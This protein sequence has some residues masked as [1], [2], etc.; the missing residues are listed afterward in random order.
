MTQQPSLPF[1]IKFCG[2]R[3]ARDVV[4]AVNLGAG[5]FGYNFYPK[6]SRFV[7]ASQ[8]ASLIKASKADGTDRGLSI[9]VFVNPTIEEL[10]DIL[11]IC[12]LDAIQLHGDETPDFVVN[13]TLPPIIKAISWRENSSEDE[14][15]ASAWKE[16]A[17]RF[18][19]L[20]FLVDAYDPIQRGGTGKQA[21]WDLLYPRPEP[22]RDVPLILAGGL[23]AENVQQAVLATRADAVDTASGIETQP[24]LKNLDKMRSFIEEAR[25]GFT[26]I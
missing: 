11:S 12:P 3:E 24:G 2:F 10:R 7:P 4:E 20:G 17:S 26:K 23:T 19:F 25:R 1:Q 21:R 15:I 18:P 5:A 16:S 14:E 13:E 9:G 22:L 8:A 6:S